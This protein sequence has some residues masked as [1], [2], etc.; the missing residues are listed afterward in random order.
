MRPIL[1]NSIF[2]IFKYLKGV[3]V[4]IIN[5]YC[6]LYK[7]ITLMLFTFVRRGMYLYRS[8]KVLPSD[9]YVIALYILSNNSTI[10]FVRGYRY[11]NDTLLYCSSSYTICCIWQ[12]KN[13]NF[14]FIMENCSDAFEI[15]QQS[16]RIKVKTSSLLDIETHQLF[17]CQVS[18][19]S[20]FDIS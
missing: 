5:F 9:S 6:T 10:S 1:D 19:T 15:E 17:K 14:E 12:G 2:K 20:L 8:V 16:G 3:K 11:K 7:Q 18:S 13:A 4:I